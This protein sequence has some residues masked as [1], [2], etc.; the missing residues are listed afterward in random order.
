MNENKFSDLPPRPEKFPKWVKSSKFNGF[1]IM[2]HLEKE[3]NML[4][5]LLSRFIIYPLDLSYNDLIE[6][7]ES[8]RNTFG[9]T[10]IDKKMIK[11]IPLDKLIELIRAEDDWFDKEKN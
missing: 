5:A 9:N 4:Q 2:E 11:N 8:Y 3:I 7:L 10:L 6:R 1:A